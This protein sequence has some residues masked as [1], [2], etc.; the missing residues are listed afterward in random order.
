MYAG[1]KR[2]GYQLF[3]SPRKHINIPK[4][5]TSLDDFQKGVYAELFSTIMT[6]ANRQISYCQESNICSQRKNSI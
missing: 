2:R 6:K 5:A 3:L 4:R 1:R